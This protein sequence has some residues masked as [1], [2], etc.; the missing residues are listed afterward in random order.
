MRKSLVVLLLGILFFVA[1]CGM[2]G[3]HSMQGSNHNSGAMMSAGTKMIIK[4]LRQDGHRIEL[5]IPPLFAGVAAGI[6]I[7]LWSEQTKQPVRAG[8]VFVYT[9]TY[10]D[11]RFVSENL[12]PD[13][14][15]EYEAAELE[16]GVYKVALL[17]DRIGRMKFRTEISLIEDVSELFVLEATQE[18][19]Q[20]N[21][22]V[23]RKSN[24]T[25]LAIIGGIGMTAM[26]LFMGGMDHH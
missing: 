5:E 17:P 9:K 4:E 25:L 11:D 7:R 23:K 22:K 26:M 14:D 13:F 6:T 19:V 8:T 18:I 24:F 15:F 12:E 1:G 3:N 16:K 2:M 21:K 20:A 10:S